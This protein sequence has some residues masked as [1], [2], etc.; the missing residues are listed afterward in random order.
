L[1][2]ARK[3]RAPSH[4]TM[5]KGLFEEFL[6][7]KPLRSATL[8]PAAEGTPEKLLFSVSRSEHAECKQCQ[9]ATATLGFPSCVSRVEVTVK[10]PAQFELQRNFHV[11]ARRE[12]AGEADG[13][14]GVT[15]V[16][17]PEEAL[18]QAL[19]NDR[20]GIPGTWELFPP[21]SGDSNDSTLRSLSHLS[22]G[23]TLGVVFKGENVPSFEV[24]F[25]GQ[26]GTSV[27]HLL[28]D[29]RLNRV[30]ETRLSP[31]ITSDL[32]STV[33][34][35][36]SH[37]REFRHHIRTNGR[38]SRLVL[39]M[40][41]GQAR[42]VCV[43]LNGYKFPA[44]E[45]SPEG[46]AIFEAPDFQEVVVGED[47]RDGAPSLRDMF[48]DTSSTRFLHLGNFP[49]KDLVFDNEGKDEAKFSL[50]VYGASH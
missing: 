32:E 38:M 25:F 42:P 24:K 13:E 2:P 36:C 5:D 47:E 30:E 35:T 12:H 26:K 43:E 9:G 20:I 41:K 37:Q 46:Q 49:C 50:C 4:V 19:R 11:L 48:G 15:T 7:L 40:L 18:P 31:P 39:R 1:K 23:D 44:Q 14:N 16:F 34:S 45:I 27:T 8:A 28:G 10:G 6:K 17:L 22:S 33:F 3:V 29:P 21:F